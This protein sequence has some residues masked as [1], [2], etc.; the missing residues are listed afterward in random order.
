ML[1]SIGETNILAYFA[2][3]FAMDS[4]AHDALNRHI[5]HDVLQGNAQSDHIL[6]VLDYLLVGA[7]LEEESLLHNKLFMKSDA[8]LVLLQ[9]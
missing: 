4:F 9:N 5:F 7:L 6:V 3:H 8:L 2:I 1:E